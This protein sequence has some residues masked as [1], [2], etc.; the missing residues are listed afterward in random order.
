MSPAK[1]LVALV[2]EPPTLHPDA[3][4][5]ELGRHEDG[6]FV[7]FLG[8]HTR[9]FEF[10]TRSDVGE[11]VGERAVKSEGNVVWHVQSCLRAA[12]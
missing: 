3:I 1:G 2:L 11:D 8:P 4:M 5:V 7:W 9:D 10:F 6:W 12:G